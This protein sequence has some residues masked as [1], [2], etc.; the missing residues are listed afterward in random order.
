MRTIKQRLSELE[1]HL[2][3]RGHLLMSNSIASAICLLRR[4]LR[5]A[6]DGRTLIHTTRGLGYYLASA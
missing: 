2:Y 3:G 4:K 6:A 1:D 5:E